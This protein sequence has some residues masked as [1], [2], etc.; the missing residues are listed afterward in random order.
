MKFTAHNILLDGKRTVS[1]TDMLLCD[2]E[3]WKSIVRTLDLFFPGTKEERK[4]LRVVD[5][6]PLE[7]GYAVEFAKL[8]FDTLGIEAREENVEKCNYAKEKL[9]LSNLKF[10]K[11]D[12]RNLPNYGQFDIVFC[13][14]L[15]YHLNDPA[16]F[17]K[18]MSSNNTKLLLLNTHFAPE[19]D[20]RYELG[21]IN[22]YVIAPIQKR[23]KLLERTKNWRLSPLTRNEGYRG[24]WLKEYNKKLDKKKVEKLLWSAYN[25]DRSFWLTRKDLT[26]AIHDAG[27]HSVFEQFDYTG[28][29]VPHN[30]NYH[31]NR[32]VFVAVKK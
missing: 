17:L 29:L 21:F 2:S 30:I 31:Y 22:K 28:D 13:Y 8:G 25:N 32:G 4:K 5:L 14:G 6:G 23:T 26:M 9:Q 16:A 7:G 24:R 19:R 20:I 18:V 10:V 27:Y 11:D 12:V 3:A 15:L 1:D